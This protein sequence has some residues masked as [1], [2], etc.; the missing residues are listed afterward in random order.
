[1]TTFK[2]DYDPHFYS[3]FKRRG[4][5]GL[6]AYVFLQHIYAW[7]LTASHKMPSY[8]SYLRVSTIRKKYVYIF[9]I[10][11]IYVSLATRQLEKLISYINLY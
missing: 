11:P 7:E 2:G 5:G 3:D 9:S 1:M 6:H 8:R 10:H 4:G